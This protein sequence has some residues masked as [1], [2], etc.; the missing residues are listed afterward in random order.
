MCES[1]Y[2]SIFFLVL[3]CRVEMILIALM[4]RQIAHGKNSCRF[5]TS[6]G[7]ITTLGQ[8]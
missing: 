4:R 6:I 3:L 5:P 1:F 2:V 7:V 8:L